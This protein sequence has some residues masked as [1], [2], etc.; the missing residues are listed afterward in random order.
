V[1]CLPR[2]KD[3][4]SEK[5]EKERCFLMDGRVPIIKLFENQ[6]EKELERLLPIKE[7]IVGPQ[8]DLARRV[9]A[10]RTKNTNFE[11]KEKM[12]DQSGEVSNQTAF[13]EM[14]HWGAAIEK[15]QIFPRNYWPH[16]Q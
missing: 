14:A 3:T 16:T 13:A 10:L 6:K 2:K 8:P 15:A 9:E 11:G 5:A 12:V 1:S 7:I 4:T